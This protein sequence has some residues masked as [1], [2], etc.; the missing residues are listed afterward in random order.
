MYPNKNVSLSPFYSVSASSYPSHGYPYSL[1]IQP[2]HGILPSSQNPAPPPCL[3]D[4]F[5][6]GPGLPTASCTSNFQGELH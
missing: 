1:Y 2:N 4:V 6:S 3:E 5:S